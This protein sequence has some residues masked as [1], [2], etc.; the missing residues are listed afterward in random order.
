VVDL[1]EIYGIIPDDFNLRPEDFDHQ[2]KIHGVGHVY[3]V[4]YHCL[5]LGLALNLCEDAKLAFIAAYI[6]DLSR[7]H[8]GRCNEHGKWA[9]EKKLPLYS[10]LL[11]RYKIDDFKLEQI[12]TAIY[13]HSL[14]EELPK[15]HFCWTVT[16]I[17]KDAD[18]LDRIR[19]GENDL[20]PKYLRFAESIKSIGLARDLYYLSS[21]KPV[22]YFS[23]IISAGNMLDSV[24]K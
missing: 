3:R 11:Q 23:E 7:K 21:G 6:H 10:V 8:D 5:N 24:Q 20:N 9:S 13:Y 2:S 16:S 15:D 1:A 4:M 12:R 17:L 18:A 19:L 14:P 22:I